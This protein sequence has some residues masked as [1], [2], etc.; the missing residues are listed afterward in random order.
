MSGPTDAA[1]KHAPGSFAPVIDRNKCEG[2]AGCVTVC[3]T[4]V[5]VIGKLPAQDR[6]TLSLR[7]RLKGWAHGWNQALLPN[8]AACEGCGLCV[9]ACPE[10]AITLQRV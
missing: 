1:C 4:K 9:Q 3:P 5:F 2:K 7:G 6:K 8:L 10:H